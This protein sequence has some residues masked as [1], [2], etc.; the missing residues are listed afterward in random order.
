MAAMNRAARVIEPVGEEVRS[1]HAA[2]YEIFHRMYD[3]QL[4]YREMMKEAWD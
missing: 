2:R 4:T 3:D 1:Y